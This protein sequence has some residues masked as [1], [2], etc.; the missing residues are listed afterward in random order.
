MWPGIWPWGGFQAG[1]IWA[2]Y[3]GDKEVVGAIDSGLA[4]LYAG[5]VLP[6]KLFTISKNWLALGGHLSPGL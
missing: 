5:D 4:G 3:V 6:A 1:E 2:C